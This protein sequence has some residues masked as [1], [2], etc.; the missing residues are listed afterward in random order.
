MT[1]RLTS[2][3]RRRFLKTAVHASAL[4]AVPQVIPGSVLGK[5]DAVAPS[6]RTTLGGIGVDR[7]LRKRRQ[8]GASSRWLAAAGIVPRAV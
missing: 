6:E 1:K 3:P 5:D 2:I 7:P 4:L 8:A